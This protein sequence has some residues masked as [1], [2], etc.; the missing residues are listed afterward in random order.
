MNR[1]AIV[2]GSARGIGAAVAGRLVG[3]GIDVAVLDVDVT[4]A[5]STAAG[6]VRAGGRA[7]AIGVDVSDADAVSTAVDEVVDRFGP[8]CILVNNAGITRDNMVF[9][10]SPADWDLVI[11]VNLRGTFLMTHAVAEHMAKLGW[12]RV[13]NLSSIAAVGNP[14]QANYSAAKAGIEGLTKT[15]ALELGPLNVTVNAVAPGY[16]ATEMTAALAAQ[17]GRTAEEHQAQAAATIPLRR[18]G[19]PEDIADVVAFLASD[20]ASFVS[21]QIIHV[22]GGP[23]C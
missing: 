22:A 18:V 5:Q 1:V 23:V 11:N 9:S 13:V 8:P 2:T 17:A 21:G 20:H 14:G 6:L 10:L 16:V 4:A 12:G 15:L 7:G 19:R 3:D